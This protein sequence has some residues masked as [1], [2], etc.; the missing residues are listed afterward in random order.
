MAFC[1]LDKQRKTG[2][3]PVRGRRD[4]ENVKHSRESLAAA[5]SVE[6]ATSQT[7]DK[8][9]FVFKRRRSIAAVPE[10]GAVCVYV[11]SFV[12]TFFVKGGHLRSSFQ[13]ICQAILSKKRGF[14]IHS[15]ALVTLLDVVETHKLSSL[16]PV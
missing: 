5:P 16:V 10:S 12:C 14:K 8:N 3:T 2:N 6:V 13:T 11:Y 1:T 7:S 15:V 9:V 4:K